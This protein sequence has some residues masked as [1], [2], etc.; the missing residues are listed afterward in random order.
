MGS[1]PTSGVNTEPTTLIEFG[2]WLK[3]RGFKETTIERKIRFLKYLDLENL[4]NAKQ[5]IM[6]S[7][8]IDKMKNYALITLK[9]YAEFKRKQLEIEKV[10]CTND[11][12]VFYV[13]TPEMVK[14]IISN[15]H[16]LQL[17]IAVM[18]AVECGLTASEVMLIQKTDFDFQKQTVMVRGVK[19]HKGRVYKVSEHLINLAKRFNFKWSYDKEEE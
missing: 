6:N 1:N 10:R 14:A 18:L 2:F 3:K 4:E 5:Q 8:W 9:Q 11:E 19:G 7:D 12:K 15:T 17:K 13:P 16:S